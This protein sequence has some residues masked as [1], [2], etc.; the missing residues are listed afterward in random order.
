MAT[1][2]L[3]L[4]PLLTVE[5]QS[6]GMSLWADAEARLE[7]R[8]ERLANRHICGTGAYRFGRQLPGDEF[9]LVEG[10]SDRSGEID[11][12]IRFARVWQPAPEVA[13]RAR[14]A[15][16]AGYGYF[17]DRGWVTC[18]APED[19]LEWILR[20]L[21]RGS[22]ETRPCTLALTIQGW[23]DGHRFE[24]EAFSLLTGTRRSFPLD[25]GVIY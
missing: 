22:A 9:D 3:R 21:E 25:P 13:D 16:S 11:W 7:P 24:V 8:A 14:A 4:V 23:E 19:D 2:E 18:T 15:V 5:I 17:G 10:A 12:Q 6:W 1:A 20:G